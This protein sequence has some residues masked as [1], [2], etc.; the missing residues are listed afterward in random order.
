MND[1]Y[2]DGKVVWIT[3]AS[4]GIGEALAVGLAA[5]GAQIILSARKVGALQ[6]VK[7]KC[8]AVAANN[9]LVLPFDVT[10]EASV[11]KAAEQARS[12]SGRIDMLINNAGI[13]QRSSCL[14]TELSTYRTLFEIDVFAPIVLT[15]AV[16]PIMIEQGSG[17]IIVTSSVAG[18][19]GVPFR[20]GYSAA[21][22][23]VMGFFDS[24]RAEVS[25]HNI[26]VSTITPGFI[27][28]NVSENA[29]AGD[30]QAYGQVDRDIAGGMSPQDCADVI[31]K[32]LAKGKTEIAV[33]KGLEMHAL[34]IKRFFPKWLEKLLVTQ[35]QKRSEHHKFK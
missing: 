8:D 6:V 31:I 26:A 16:L 1:P 33:G 5:Q 3:G 19:M 17:H 20:T 12:L 13:S 22:H 4:S 21:K 7:Q 35:Y 10:D 27:R 23:A 11:P 14:E 30:G 32:N 9:H 24:L 29:L 34:W 18:K 15:K 28:T 2:F 25:H